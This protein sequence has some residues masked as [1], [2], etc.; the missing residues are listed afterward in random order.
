ML[1]GQTQKKT[2]TLLSPGRRPFLNRGC[3]EALFRR[4][5][6]NEGLGKDFYRKGNF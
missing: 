6:V 1:N 4:H 5:S 2:R 3:D